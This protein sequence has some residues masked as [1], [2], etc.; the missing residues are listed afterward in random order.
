[1]QLKPIWNC[2]T[3][4]EFNPICVWKCAAIDGTLAKWMAVEGVDGFLFNHRA[5]ICFFVCLRWF[6]GIDAIWLFVIEQ[7][8]LFTIDTERST[9][10]WKAHFPLDLRTEND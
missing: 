6:Y 2:E 7:K 1:M 9:Q 3:V 8:N 10:Q 5:C 4:K